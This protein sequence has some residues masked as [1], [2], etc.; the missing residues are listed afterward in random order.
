MNV[1]HGLIDTYVA[2][3]NDK[4]MAPGASQDHVLAM[5]EDPL[6]AG[7]VLSLVFY[8]QPAL[9]VDLQNGLQQHPLWTALV[10]KPSDQFATA[11]IKQ[12]DPLNWSTVAQLML[13]FPN[14]PA[15]QL[16]NLLELLKKK[17][18]PSPYKDTIT[19]NVMDAKLQPVS[20][21]NSV[22]VKAQGML[23]LSQEAYHA[24]YLQHRAAWP[25]HKCLY[26][27]MVFDHSHLYEK[28][29]TTTFKQ[30]VHV[31]FDSQKDQGNVL[32]FN[33]LACEC[34]VMVRT[35]G[36][37]LN[38]LQFTDRSFIEQFEQVLFA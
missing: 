37:H 36:M 30:G 17:P 5:L 38:V 15:S 23:L 3:M 20:P 22:F 13:K 6:Q 14:D 31:Q 21:S 10:L 4:K 25:L 12:V 32:L 2:Y 27:D 28:V 7:E 26:I 19:I 34:A 24:S 8:N 1:A 29:W 16:W 18:A 11:S 33:A 35:N 9:F